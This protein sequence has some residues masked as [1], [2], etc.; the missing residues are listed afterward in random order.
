[1]SERRRCEGASAARRSPRVS[2]NGDSTTLAA[3]HPPPPRHAFVMLAV[4]VVM[5]SAILV[6]TSLLFVAQ[7]EAAGAAG[8]GD[9]AQTRALLWSGAQAIMAELRDQRKRI[10]AGDLPA[11]DDQYSIYETSTHAGVVRLL[12]VSRGGGLLAPEAGKLDLN[13]IDAESLA[14]TELVDRATAE[15]II[16]WRARLGRPVQSISELLQVPGITVETLYGSIDALL[17]MDRALSNGSERRVSAEESLA[18]PA[19]SLADLLTV[20]SFEPAVQASGKLRIN[21][22]VPWSDELARRVEERFGAD[23]VASLKRIVEAGAKFDSDAKIV[24]ALRELN[25]PPESWVEIL[26]AFTT[27]PGDLHFGRLDI[28]TASREA[29]LALP[30]V[31]EEQ[32]A[33]IVSVRQELAQEERATIVWP[34]INQ[35]LKPEQYEAL[36]GRITTRCWTYS[37]RIAAG[38]V[39]VDQPNGPLLNPQIQELVIDL[40]GPKPRIA[41]L[42]DITLLQDAAL[43]ALQAT[44]SGAADE[45]LQPL[46]DADVQAEAPADQPARTQ[47]ARRP[48]R[49]A[50]PGRSP[51]ATAAD[52]PRNLED[53]PADIDS[54]S[55]SPVGRRIGRWTAGE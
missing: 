11:L 52:G 51:N 42:R 6:A 28:N 25:V 1:M 9:G 8:A 54:A 26:D 55:Q 5:L 31:T 36:A 41:Y 50:A 12:P 37:L 40:S 16:A 19:R 27:E 22:N 15:A 47:P 44:R 17:A 43:M 46:S 18:A 53:A 3:S 39:N 7:S 34:A 30:G 20:F 35:I 38:E 23:A 4:L 14:R 10:L 24:Q 49:I 21:L 2:R 32:A 48:G 29:L 33:Q 45:F 13:R